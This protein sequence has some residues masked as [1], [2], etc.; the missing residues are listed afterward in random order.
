MGR[1][2]EYDWFT[3][4][5]TK[6]LFW[7]INQVLEDCVKMVEKQS[8]KRLKTIRLCQPTYCARCAHDVAANS[9]SEVLK[10]LT[11]IGHRKSPDASSKCY[12]CIPRSI[13][14]QPTFAGLADFLD[15]AHQAIKREAPAWTQRQCCE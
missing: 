15:T 2:T 13:N 10:Q 4:F 9:A 5:A 12:M 3:I 7:L 8:L 14:S 11:M 1:T 6:I